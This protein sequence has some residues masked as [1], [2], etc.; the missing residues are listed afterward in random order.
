MYVCSFILAITL[1]F[2]LNLSLEN[3]M[4]IFWKTS[5]ITPILQPGYS[6]KVS[7][8]RPVRILN[9]KGI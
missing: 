7:N 9:S 8:Y 3:G 5:F 2:M 4:L 6:S 1:Y